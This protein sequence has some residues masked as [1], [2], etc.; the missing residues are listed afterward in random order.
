MMDDK[1]HHFRDLKCWQLGRE[2]RKRFYSIAKDL[3]EY[4][5][6]GLASQIRRAAVS[7]T[8]MS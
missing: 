7:V 2:L 8:A 3:P 5:K 6:Y 1:R 4:E